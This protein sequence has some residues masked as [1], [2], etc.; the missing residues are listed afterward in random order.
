MC[1]AW[2]RPSSTR[3]AAFPAASCIDDQ[4]PVGEER[5]D[6][7]NGI[8]EQIERIERPQDTLARRQFQQSLD[9]LGAAGDD[10]PG[11]DAGP[12]EGDL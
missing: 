3:P 6:R 11:A 5:H 4:Q 2:S 9:Q 8:T 12:V 7:A 10:R 1:A